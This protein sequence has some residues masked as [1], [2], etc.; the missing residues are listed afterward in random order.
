MKNEVRHGNLVNCKSTIDKHKVFMH[1]NL[2]LIPTADNIKTVT[3]MRENAI[4]LLKTV[5]QLGTVYVFQHSN[6]Q[7]VMLS[8]EEFIR[9]Q[10]LVEDRLDEQEA[11]KLSKEKR[12][13][14]IS[15]SKIIS[16]YQKARV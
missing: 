6:P 11:I 15:L 9:L 4:S 2:M 5:K 3:D 16:K 12:G 13:K 10:E 14:G 1:N 8:M 7:A